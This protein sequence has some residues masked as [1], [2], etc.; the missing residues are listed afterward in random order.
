MPV[1]ITYERKEKGK[2]LMAGIRIYLVALSLALFAEYSRAG[3]YY[4]VEFI[5]SPPKAGEELVARVS[6]VWGMHC[7]PTTASATQAGSAIV[8]S[9]AYTDACD[10][11]NVALTHDYPLGAYPAGSYTFDVEACAYNAPP[12]PSSCNIGL[13]I[14]LRIGAGN[15][16]AAPVPTISARALLA[17][18][19]GLLLFGVRSKKIQPA[20][21]VSK[22]ATRLSS[23]YGASSRRTPP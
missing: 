11:D 9:L 21:R 22:S 13:E 19:I 1:S 4:A 14:P 6:H 2:R 10:P 17:L 8:L 12:L 7:W 5:P 18:V 3:T 23:G 20:A 16:S 15:A